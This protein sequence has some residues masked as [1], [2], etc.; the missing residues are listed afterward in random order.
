VQTLTFTL[1][2]TQAIAGTVVDVQTRSPIPG[3]EVLL[4]FEE[5]RRLVP[6]ASSW[7]GLDGSF[8]IETPPRTSLTLTARAAGYVEAEQLLPQV[9][10]G[11]LTIALLQGGTLV[12]EIGSQVRS[13]QPP[14]YRLG[15]LEGDPEQVVIELEAQ[16]R[17]CIGALPPGRYTARVRGGA[18]EHRASFNIEAGRVTT[19]RVGAE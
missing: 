4:S 13:E 10:R 5:P 16:A 17:C 6:A 3:A 9:S 19:V 7:T 1:E 8:R 2:P 12:V 18:G 11:P 15:I 14:P